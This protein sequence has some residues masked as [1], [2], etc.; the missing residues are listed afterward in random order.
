ME[1]GGGSSRIPIRGSGHYSTDTELNRL[2][3][4]AQHTLTEEALSSYGCRHDKMCKYEGEATKR[5]SCKVG[6]YYMQSSCTDDSK[7]TTNAIR[8][9]LRI[10]ETWRFHDAVKAA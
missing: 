2:N 8:H 1:G 6:S 9:W 4:T 7:Q 3:R 5:R 10:L